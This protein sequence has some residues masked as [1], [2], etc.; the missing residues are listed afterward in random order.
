MLNIRRPCH[1]VYVKLTRLA[2]ARP[3]TREAP[4]LDKFKLDP[5]Y[6]PQMALKAA[7]C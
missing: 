3:W 2:L 5:I 4:V 1:A 6:R 7:G